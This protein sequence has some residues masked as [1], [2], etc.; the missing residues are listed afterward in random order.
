M[1]FRFVSNPGAAETLDMC[2]EGETSG[3]FQNNQKLHTG[4][5]C[6]EKRRSTHMFS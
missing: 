5:T 2:N 6:S 4:C 3:F 1:G